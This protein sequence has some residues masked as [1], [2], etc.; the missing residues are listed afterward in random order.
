[1]RIAL[2]EPFFGGS[3]KR[4][5]EDYR[6]F[7]GHEVHLFTSPG[8]HWKWRMHESGINMAETFNASPLTFDRIM[9]SDM[10][11]LTTFKAFAQPKGNP[12][13]VLYFHENQLTYPWSSQD[14]DRKNGR[15]RH[16][17]WI[18]YVSALAADQVWFNSDYHR[19]SFLEAL[20]VFLNAYPDRRGMH[21]VEEISKNS[22][23]VPI[24]LNLKRFDALK[25]ENPLK[26]EEPVLLWNHRWE[27]DKNPEAFFAACLRLRH[28]GI[29]FHLA[30]LGQNNRL[31]PPIFDKAKE[32]L[33][34]H[35]IQWGPVDSFDEYASWLHRSD[36]IPVTSNQ[37]FFGISAVEAMYCGVVPLLPNR[38]AFPEH[39][40][41]ANYFYD[42][43]EE[44][45][46]RLKEWIL[47]PNK[48]PAPVREQVLK[49]T[50]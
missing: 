7:S 27:Y 12:E 32:K 43:D 29:Q 11:D 28:D 26:N 4:W 8:R 23:T 37:D 41:G 36:I 9:V 17:G 10:L 40:E 21:R 18:N 19:N 44:L 5:S 2:I 49:Y 25:P 24:Q 15:S 31:Y 42:T 38:L 48:K 1:M 22:S 6:D 30:V 35:I 20:P 47:H 14:R 45:Y 16:Y 34:E 13:Y 3:H 33:T 46:E 39:I 50:Y